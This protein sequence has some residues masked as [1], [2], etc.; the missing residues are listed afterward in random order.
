MCY[1]VLVESGNYIARSTIIPIPPE[2]LSSSSHKERIDA[3]TTSVHDV[4]GDHKKAI[5]QGEAINEEDLYY[6]AFFESRKEIKGLTYPWDKD[7][8]DVPLHK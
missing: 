4:I 2:E 1:W 5:V 6:D 3:F 8:E 7:L